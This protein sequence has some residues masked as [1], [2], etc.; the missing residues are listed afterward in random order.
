MSHKTGKDMILMTTVTL[1]RWGNSSGVRI[2]NH[3][4]KRMNLIDGAEMEAILTPENHILLRPLT[5]TEEDSN[6]ELRA[7]LKMLLSKIKP[8]SLRHEEIDFGIEGDEII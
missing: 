1:S 2:P 3:F 6:E 4:L 7:H 8:D 5:Q